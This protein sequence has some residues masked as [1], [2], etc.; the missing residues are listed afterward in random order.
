MRVDSATFNT[1]TELL[2]DLFF[3]AVFTSLRF[4]FVHGRGSR[5]TIIATWFVVDTE[6][7]YIEMK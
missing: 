3:A 6:H 5:D 7:L 4:E 2:I 1:S